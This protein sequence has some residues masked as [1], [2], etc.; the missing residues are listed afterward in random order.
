MLRGTVHQSDA[1]HSS[2]SSRKDKVRKKKRRK[3]EASS[4]DD[5]ST[6][7]D[8]SSPRTTTKKTHK[9]YRVRNGLRLG[10]LMH[11]LDAQRVL[12]AAER[13]ENMALDVQRAMLKA[14]YKF[15]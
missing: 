6:S 4:S 3:L 9:R 11:K 13:R 5:S 1:L 7:D 2:D 10:N 14:K 15:K 8:S 12:H